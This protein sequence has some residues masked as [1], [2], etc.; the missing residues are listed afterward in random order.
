MSQQEVLVQFCF[1]FFSFCFFLLSMEDADG[2]QVMEESF[3]GGAGFI[4][5]AKNA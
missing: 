1:V 5:N 2:A 3:G 4:K